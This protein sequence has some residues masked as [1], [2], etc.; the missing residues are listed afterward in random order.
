MTHHTPLVSD[1]TASE[2]TRP[3]CLET[4]VTG[5]NPDA[6]SL[7][8]SLSGISTRRP[9]RMNFNV[10]AVIARSKVFFDTDRYR[11]AEG[12]SHG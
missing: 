4:D 11:A 2:E 7:R 8:I 12:K 5:Y 9:I 10:P 1:G 6:A 3:I